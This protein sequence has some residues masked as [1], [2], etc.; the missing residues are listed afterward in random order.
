LADPI[1]HLNAALAD[2]CRISGQAGEGGMAPVY[3]AEDP[4]RGLER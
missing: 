3:L 1:E 4:K 2:R